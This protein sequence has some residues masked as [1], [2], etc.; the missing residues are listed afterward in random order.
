MRRLSMPRS[1]S[2]GFFVDTS[3][4]TTFFPFGTKRSGAKL[5]ARA[6]SYSRK[7]PSTSV[8]NTASATAS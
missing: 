4:S 5:P 1:S 3:P 6:V 8:W 2:S 7:K